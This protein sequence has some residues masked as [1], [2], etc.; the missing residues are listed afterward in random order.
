M[1]A[2]TAVLVFGLLMAALTMPSGNPRETFTYAANCAA[3]AL[4]LSLSIELKSGL[5]AMLRTDIVML[6]VLFALTFV[7]FLIPQREIFEFVVSPEGAVDGSIA[8]LIGFMGIALGRH[9]FPL[10]P[11]PGVRKGLDLSPKAMFRLYLLAFFVGY[12]HIFLAVNFDVLEAMRQ[13]ALP[14]FSQSWGRGRLGGWADLLVELGA[15]IYLIPPL[16]GCIYAQA[17]RYSSL[18]KFAVAAIFF[19]TLYYGFAG[20]TRNVFGTYMITFCGAYL[21]LQP[22]I[23][24]KRLVTFVAPFGVLT[25]VAMYFMLE[26]RNQGLGNYSFTESEFQGV[27]VDS[28]LTVI[29]KLTEVFPRVHSYLGLEIP[30]NALIR[31]IPRAIWP[32]KPEGL[33]IGMEEALGADGGLTLAS[34]FV[35]EAYMAAG[36]LGVFIAGLFFG[37]A[38][39]RWNR[40]GADLSSNY[41]LILYVSGFFAAAIGM[42]SLLSVMPTTLPTLALWIYGRLFLKQAQG[43]VKMAKQKNLTREVRYGSSPHSDA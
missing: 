27:F 23:T 19:F 8:V 37:A 32:S 29:S 12:M 13:M 3:I 43:P 31:P 30:F 15:L 5:R 2:A 38:A 1:G 34:T 4:F 42:R 24:F 7:E 35:G 33:S 11:P 9:F 41:K 28:N 36:N 6:L 17:A 10:V 39:S 20:G 26:F 14:R 25:L 16:T 22:N 40:V 18:Q 21:A